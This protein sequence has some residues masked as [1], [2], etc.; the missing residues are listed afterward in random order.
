MSDF[1]FSSRAQAPGTL[2]RVLEMY[3]AP[4]TERFTEYHGEWGSLAVARCAHDPPVVEEDD[5]FLSVL[6]GEPVIRTV[7]EGTGV[8]GSARRRALH[9]LLEADPEPAWD[10][11]LDGPFAVL[12]I[13]KR[14]GSGTLISDLMAFIPLFNATAR[15]PDGGGLVLGTHVDAVARAAGR[16][17]DFDPVSAA[18]LLSN[19]SIAFPHTL[20]PGVEQFAP[21]SARRFDARRGWSAER[22]AY[23]QPVERSGYGSVYE[24]AEALR[25]A[26]A[27]DVQ[28]ACEG[29]ERVG[30]LLS[31]GED[32]RVVLGA[33][34]SGKEVRAFI[35]SDSENREVRVAQRVAR[36]YSAEFVFGP[37]DPEHYLRGFGDVTA[38][39]GSSQLFTDVHGYE[40]HAA[41]GI[42]DMPVVLGGFSAD[43]LLKLDYAGKALKKKRAQNR[44][45]GED[46]PLKIPAVPGVREELLREV[47]ERRKAH[48]RWMAEL[49]PESAAEWY[50]LWPFSMRKHAANLHGNRRLFRTHEPFQSNAVVK[51]AASVPQAWKLD[52]RL[53]HLAMRAFMARSWYIP[54]GKARFPYFGSRSNLLLGAGLGVAR[55]IRAAA[56]GELFANQGPWPKWKK[57]M[58][59]DTVARKY[60][61]Y[62]V[63]DSPFRSIF[64]STS[65]EEIERAIRTEW[66]PLRQ[67]LTLQLAFLAGKAQES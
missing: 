21:G 25:E 41:L 10:E 56:T 14:E 48:R 24:A 63:W 51:L 18:D 58:R 49:R 64:T 23:W 46:A 20:Y 12:G 42:Q 32:S 53:F 5:S 2:Q 54:H 28:I 27:E 52:R 36:A 15:S 57:I 31:A 34:P 50:R 8:R 37:R 40:F 26:F 65:D 55:G 38:M 67:L 66:A 4:V 45:A 17:G 11:H 33:V 13:D 16:H 44:P 9:E 62:P 1:L 3:L 19:M 39:V 30:L 59:T 29:L 47:V 60:Q 22:R 7:A 6:I 35:F 61:R 43:S